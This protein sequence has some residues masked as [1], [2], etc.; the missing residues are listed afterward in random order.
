VY[1]TK[2]TTRKEQRQTRSENTSQRGCDDSHIGRDHRSWSIRALIDDRPCIRSMMATKHRD[3]HRHLSHHSI[4]LT[5]TVRNDRHSQQPT[6]TGLTVSSMADS[7]NKGESARDKSYK[8]TT[9][10]CTTT[11]HVTLTGK[12]LESKI[13]EQDISPRY[14]LP[15]NHARVQTR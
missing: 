2:I 6:N 12:N 3:G 5:S 1:L 7:T 8:A 11:D 13:H 9:V 14:T 10:K 4:N 15:Q